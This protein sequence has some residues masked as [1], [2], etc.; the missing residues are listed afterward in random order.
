M[1]QL[2]IPFI[3]GHRGSPLRQP[4]NTTASFAEALHSGADGIELDTQ[5]TSDGFVVIMHDDAVDATTNGSG[6]V[7]DMLLDSFL[8][9]KTRQRNSKI[10]TEAPPTLAETLDRF[11]AIARVV[12]VEIKPSEDTRLAKATAEIIS[13]HPAQK[14]ILC[15]SFDETA[16]Q[17]LQQEYPHLRRALLFPNSAIHGLIAGA[18]GQIGCVYR[19]AQLGCE[20]IHPHWRLVNP[21]FIT[22]AHSLDL[23]VTIWT[24]D[25][26]AKAQSFAKW[27]ADGIITNNPHLLSSLH[28]TY[29]D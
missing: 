6:K 15:S 9:L 13:A 3:I 26:L 14:N 24:V 28:D 27:G 18:V 21:R 16:L 17:F 10:Y 8:S 29:I 4:E 5:L 23:R 20:A 2:Q 25:D 1:A 7:N 11:G 19:A 22:Y 12:N